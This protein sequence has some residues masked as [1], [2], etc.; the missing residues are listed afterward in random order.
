MVTLLLFF[1]FL[2][3]LCFGSFANVLIYRL[4]NNISIITPPSHCPRC[5]SPIP[6][7]QNIPVISYLILLGKCS[8]CKSFIPI[9]YP[10][11]ETLVGVLFWFATYNYAIVFPPTFLNI[12]Q[13]FSI[14][15]F[16]LFLTVL[17]FIDL[18]HQILPDKLT[19]PGVVLGFASSFILPFNT[20][21]ESILGALLGAVVPTILILVYA[22]RKIEAMGW[23]DVKL[24][25]MVG[26]Y[27]GWKGALLTFLFGSI[28]GTIVGGIYILL[29]SKDK[30]TPL[31]FGTFL[32]IAAIVTLFWS[33]LFWNWYYGFSGGL[34]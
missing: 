8:K 6:F 13:I 19:L 25:A 23:G 28:I 21:V 31:P 34:P 29:F 3:G 14:Y 4:P 11:V 18:E 20:P 9:R 16:L 22:L 17:M 26:A 32:G 10:L 27:L 12:L 7:Y 30:R 15:I 2:L 5:Q 24:M 1:S 33:D